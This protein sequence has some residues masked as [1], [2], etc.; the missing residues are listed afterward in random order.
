MNL[1][2]KLSLK[3]MKL[4]MH[5]ESQKIYYYKLVRNLLKKKKLG[6]NYLIKKEINLISKVLEN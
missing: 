5:G 1:I 6:F 3:E 2:Y 4:K